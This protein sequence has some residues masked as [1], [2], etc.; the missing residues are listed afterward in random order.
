MPGVLAKRRPDHID[1]D[2]VCDPQR[3]HVAPLTLVPAALHPFS[4]LM[5]Q[6]RGKMGVVLRRELRGRMSQPLGHF[7]EAHPFPA[8]PCTHHEVAAAGM[9]QVVK[10]Q[11]PDAGLLAPSFP[12]AIVALGVHRHPVLVRRPNET[13]GTRHT[14]SVSP[15]RQRLPDW[16][17]KRNPAGSPVLGGFI[18]GV[19]YDDF[20]TIRLED[21]IFPVETPK[22][23]RAHTRVHRDRED[24]PMAFRN[25]L[26]FQ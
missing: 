9:P 25:E 24:D 1:Q 4:G 13:A 26:T 21:D 5:K 14:V 6:F 18:E 20:R 19:A 7:L 3:P 15:T 10:R 16:W 2:G 12:L 11:L 8:M 17:K 22:L 23:S